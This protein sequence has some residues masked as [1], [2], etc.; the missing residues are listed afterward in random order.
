[1]KGPEVCRPVASASEQSPSPRPLVNTR[2]TV[3]IK[4]FVPRWQQT[5]ADSPLQWDE[6]FISALLKATQAIDVPVSLRLAR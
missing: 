4:V 5:R 1:M 3:Q 2:D 6:A